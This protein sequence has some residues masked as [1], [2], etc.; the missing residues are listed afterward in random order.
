MGAVGLAGPVGDCTDSD[1]VMRGTCWPAVGFIQGF[2]FSEGLAHHVQRVKYTTNESKLSLVA[3][4][5]VVCDIGSMLTGTADVPASFPVSG[6][7]L[8]L[9]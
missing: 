9:V 2:V 5:L 1:W 8:A 4:G 3:H 6:R 7:R